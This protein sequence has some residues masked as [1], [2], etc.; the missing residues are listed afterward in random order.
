[1]LLNSALRCSSK[2]VAVTS[3]YG[4]AGGGGADALGEGADADALGEGGSS[5]E[6]ALD[7]AE[8][9]GTDSTNERRRSTERH[10]ATEAEST[11]IEIPSASTARRCFIPRNLLH[12][13]T[14]DPWSILLEQ[15]NWVAEVDDFC[16]NCAAV[17]WG[18]S[19]LVRMARQQAPAAP[20]SSRGSWP[21]APIVICS[22]QDRPSSIRFK[23]RDLHSSS[24]L[25]RL[26][27]LRRTRHRRACP[28]CLE[29]ARRAPRSA[30][31]VR[32]FRGN[33]RVSSAGSARHPRPARLA[34]ARLVRARHASCSAHSELRRAAPADQPC[35]RRRAQG[36][37][38]C[39]GTALLR[40]R[41]LGPRALPASRDRAL[42]ANRP[43]RAG[44]QQ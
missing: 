34:E 1:M 20:V 19:R 24:A 21:L 43:G 10:T 41:A 18:G 42:F 44:R 30:A 31:S 25:P 12:T 37:G 16:G 22:C 35:G 2:V 15:F 14:A 28:A 26:P 6:G 9:D 17:E 4:G 5:A 39:T 29:R 27:A 3:R 32:G 11:M 13:P 36:V 33:E 8:A 40:H 38:R 7:V 23:S